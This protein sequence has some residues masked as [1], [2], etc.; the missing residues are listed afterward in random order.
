MAQCSSDSS[1]L[2]GGKFSE[3]PLLEA[4]RFPDMLGLGLLANLCDPLWVT[5][6]ASSADLHLPG[7]AS[8]S[9]YPLTTLPWSSPSTR[10]L[11]SLVP[12]LCPQKVGSHL[13]LVLDVPSRSIPGS[14][15]RCLATSLAVAQKVRLGKAWF[16][17]LPGM[18][19]LSC[20]STVAR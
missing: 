12:L 5:L 9:H 2:L 1:C 8:C 15:S 16:C 18:L 6:K 14:P 7:L 3:I 19:S 13:L 17:A 4:W 20:Q 11:P 10:E